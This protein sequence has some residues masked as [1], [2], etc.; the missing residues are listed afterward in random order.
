MNKKIYV[1]LL[2]SIA[3]LLALVAGAFAYFTTSIEGEETSTTLRTYSSGN[4]MFETTSPDDEEDVLPG[5]TGTGTTSVYLTSSSIFPVDYY[6]TIALED[7]SKARNVY[8][9]TI[10]GEDGQLLD[11]TPLTSVGLIL[12]TG[13]IAPEEVTGETGTV[14]LVVYKLIYK[15]T[16]G[17]QNI[18]QGQVI[19]TFTTCFLNPEQV[20][21]SEREIVKNL[22]S[23]DCTNCTSDQNSKYVLYDLNTTFR[24]APNEGYDHLSTIGESCS[25]DG[26]ILTVSNVTAPVTCRVYAERAGEYRVNLYCTNCTADTN[27][28]VVT[29]GSDA[30]F[31]IEADEGYTLEEA[32]VSEGCTLENGVL[33]VTG[34]SENT[35]CQVSAVED[36]SN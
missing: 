33:T 9:Q 20:G 25:V 6:C 12:S 23:V 35:T 24:V 31:T 7:G 5:W 4:V 36:T 27:T 2:A 26:N 3:V 30:T 29:S 21:H 32:T 19:K 17:N 14:H 28:K 10:S 16:G 18:E 1:P 13:T 11:E 8:V 15:E 34:V 22:V